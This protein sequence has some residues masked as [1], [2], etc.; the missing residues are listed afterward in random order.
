M[1]L[2][3]LP[4]SFIFDLDGTLVDSLPGIAMALRHALRS[5]DVA[6]TPEM[7]RKS[8]G[9]P[10]REMLK[11]MA[12][13]ASD[14]EILL[15]ERDFRSI[16]ESEG[17]RR[18]YLFSSTRETL[19]TLYALGARLFLF[20][21]KPQSAAT[22]I[23]DEL[24]IGRFFVDRLSRDSRRPPFANKGEMLR[25]LIAKHNLAASDCIVVGDSREDLNAA[26]ERGCRFV[27]ARYGYGQ[28]G[29]EDG[30]VLAEID[31]LN[32]LLALLEQEECTHDR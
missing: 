23:V 7:V 31:N 22:R 18:T 5:S 27:F 25:Q 10:V 2:A 13:S 8:I 20:T 24:G 32:E 3:T 19:Q 17:W 4:L 16:Y 15:A 6:V 21:N 12:A 9:P 28:F 29:L 1:I 14:E 11:Q 30:P 26:R